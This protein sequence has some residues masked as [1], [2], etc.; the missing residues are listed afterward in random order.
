MKVQNEHTYRFLFGS[1]PFGG[2]VTYIQNLQD[3]L[4]TRS[5][6][7]CSWVYVERNPR[8]LI[9]RIPPFSMN[10]TLKGGMVMRSRV[11]ALEKN[12]KIF[13]AAFFNHIVP[14][15]FLGEFKRRVPLIISLDATPKLLDDI[16]KWYNTSA[17][18][19][20]N[21]VK[22][23]KHNHVK[24][25]YAQAAYL[26][27]WSGWVRDSL[28]EHYG[29]SEDK[30]RVLPPGINLKKWRRRHD[31][32]T[33]AGGKESKVK[34]LFVGGEFERKGGDMLLN[35]A[36]REGLRECEFHLVTRSSVKV[37]GDNIVVHNNVDANSEELIALYQQA[38]IFALPTRADVFSLAGLEAMAMNLP[39]IITNVGGTGEIVRNGETGFLVPGDNE[40][41]LADRLLQLVRSP[42]LRAQFGKRGREIVE[43]NFNLEKSAQ[44]IVEL[45]M[46]ISNT[47]STT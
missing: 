44:T 33:P 36:N 2:I 17:G 3:T 24:Q 43:E 19:K 8:E 23:I 32:V 1:A 10:W 25:T 14:V 31:P 12:G 21:P 38:D 26:L 45:L 42:S 34:I 29:V 15:F 22:I 5:N 20:A 18:S 4:D 27:P 28:I 7:E 40:D 16:G 47:R 35:V 9:S 6:I 11:H 13:D 39:V 30:I 46:E 41:A 37:T